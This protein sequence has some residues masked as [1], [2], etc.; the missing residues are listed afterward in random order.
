[1]KKLFPVLMVLMMFY[2]CAA[3]QTAITKKDLKVETKMSDTIFLE[4]EN[5]TEK[6]IYVDLKNTSDKDID[7]L[8]VV[9][10]HLQ[11]RGYRIVTNPKTAFYILQANILF[12]GQTDPTALEQ[13][14]M[15]GFGGALAGAAIGGGIAN[16]RNG[17][18]TTGAVVG[19]LLGAG[20]EMI[21]GS[22]VKDVTYSI[23]TDIQVA[24]KTPEKVSQSSQSQL[25]QGKSSS[26]SQSSHTTTNRKKYQT[27]ICS[28]ANQVNLKFEEALPALE[29]GLAKSVAGIF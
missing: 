14:R 23:V 5:Q 24:E 12:V 25:K 21:S 7:I 6:T 22:L 1:M 19:G 10:S 29:E 3:T 15:A 18:T 26:V 2:G 13:S 17:N 11:R 8:P 27:R 28:Y 16:A 20:A 9:T 4:L